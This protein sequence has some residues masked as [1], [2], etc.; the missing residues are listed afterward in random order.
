MTG[1]RKGK[2]ILD[3]ELPCQSANTPGQAAGWRPSALTFKSGLSGP[4]RPK[5]GVGRG[6]TQGTC[7]WV[8][9]PPFTSHSLLC[10]PF[11]HRGQ[12]GTPSILGPHGPGRQQPSICLPPGHGAA[13]S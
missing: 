4:E 13:G 10:V 9:P 5:D 7:W 2:D 11:D 6:T 1:S 8:E 12:L 3:E